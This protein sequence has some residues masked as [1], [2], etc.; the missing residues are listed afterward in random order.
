[1]G[2]GQFNVQH[3]A[4][5]LEDR[6]EFFHRTP[7]SVLTGFDHRA[8]LTTIARALVRMGCPPKFGVQGIDLNFHRDLDRA[9]PMT[10]SRLALVFVV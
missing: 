8:R 6:H 2:A 5:S 3:D 7:P 4:F 9:L 1:M 10:Y